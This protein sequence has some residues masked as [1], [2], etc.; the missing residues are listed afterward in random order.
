MP[1]WKFCCA[2]QTH[3][4]RQPGSHKPQLN[5]SSLRCRLPTLTCIIGTSLTLCQA[6]AAAA[7]CEL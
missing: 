7:A 1:Y 6:A 2:Q 3:C 5:A 4:S